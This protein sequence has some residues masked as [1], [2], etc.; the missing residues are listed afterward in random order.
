MIWSVNLNAMN[1][2]LECIQE[3]KHAR[4]TSQMKIIDCGKYYIPFGK[5]LGKRIEQFLER[6]P[7][8]QPT[9]KSRST[10]IIFGQL[11]HKR[12]LR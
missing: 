2:P 4:E 6:I 7:M 1:K 3:K 10:L 12:K 9:R 5:E 11:H 8:A